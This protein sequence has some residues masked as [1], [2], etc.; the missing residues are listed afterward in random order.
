MTDTWDH[1]G[2]VISSQYRVAVLSRLAEGP[3]TPSQIA[4]DEDIGIAS[5]SHALTSLRERGFVDLL[6]SE[7]RRKG[8]VY[9]ITDDGQALWDEIEEQGLLDE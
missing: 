1:I 2:F 6:V 7:E 4:D 5:V 8:R 9:G 3:A